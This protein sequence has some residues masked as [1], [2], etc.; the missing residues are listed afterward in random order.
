MITSKVDPVRPARL[1]AHRGPR[2]T[3]PSRRS[4]PRSCGRFLPRCWSPG[5]PEVSGAAV[6]K[7]PRTGSWPVPWRRSLG[8]GQMAHGHREPRGSVRLSRL[9]VAVAEDH[10]DPGEGHPERPARL[11]AAVGG[12]ADAQL[13]DAVIA[14]P[15]ALGVDGRAVYGAR[16]GL[17]RGPG[18]A[19]RRRRRS[20]RCGHR[21]E[22]RVWETARMTAGAGLAA[23]DALRAGAGD[24]AIVL[25][26]P[27]GHHATRDIGMGFCLVNNVAVAAA[28]LVASGR[29]GCDHRLGRPSRQRDPGHLLVRP[30]SPVRVDPPVAAVS[31]HRGVPT[32]GAPVMAWAPPSTCRW[33]PH[34]TGDVYLVAVR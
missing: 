21:G 14:L 4:R 22:P 26:R 25:G 28:S 34:A 13:G 24:A 3:T 17:S 23:V 30:V 20:P 9:L 16:P 12:I 19:V 11:V 27:P 6:V 5:P 32:N 10:H 8:R 7:R 2:E 15:A 33:P 29:A 31:R 1:A 18:G